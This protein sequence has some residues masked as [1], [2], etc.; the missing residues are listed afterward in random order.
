M[1]DKAITL[2]NIVKNILKTIYP[3]ALF[4]K[5]ILSILFF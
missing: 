4:H 5:G 2:L 3:F 1:I